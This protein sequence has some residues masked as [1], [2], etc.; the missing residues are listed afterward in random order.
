MLV[1][2]PYATSNNVTVSE[3]VIALLSL[4]FRSWSSKAQSKWE[5]KDGRMHIRVQVAANSTQLL[6]E[7]RPGVGV[8][9]GGI[10]DTEADLIKA[11]PLQVSIR[12]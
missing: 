12:G 7:R 6:R 11:L 5:E 8:R 9:A 1:P 2:S 3:W 4:A 10:T